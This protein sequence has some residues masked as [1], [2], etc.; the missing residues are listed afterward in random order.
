[1]ESRYKVLQMPE[2]S[3]FHLAEN[4][5]S[6]QISEEGSTITMTKL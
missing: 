3:I 4:E 5:G 1:M 2:E 6:L